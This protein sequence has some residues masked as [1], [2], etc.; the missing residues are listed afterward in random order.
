MRMLLKWSMKDNGAWA[1]HLRKDWDWTGIWAQKEESDHS[2][3]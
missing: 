2:V 3:S 1:M